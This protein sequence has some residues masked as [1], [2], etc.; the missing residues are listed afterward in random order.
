[1]KTFYAMI[2]I[3][4]LGVS[5]FMFYMYQFVH[6]LFG[7][8]GYIHLVIFTVYTLVNIIILIGYTLGVR[9]DINTSTSK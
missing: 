8:N 2:I 1:M 4:Y 5:L 7:Y 3:L 6:Q 9:R